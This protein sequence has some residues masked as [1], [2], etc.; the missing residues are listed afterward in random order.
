VNNPLDAVP[1]WVLLVCTVVLILAS[2]EVGVRFGKYRRHRSESEKE[3]PVGSMAA[4]ALGLL[5]F[6]LAFTFGMA[7][8][9]FDIRRD[10]VLEE[11]NALGTAYL[12][13]GFLPE[14]QRAKTQTLLREYVDIRVS[15]SQ[16]GKLE[17]VVARSEE[18]H[19]ALWAEAAS[20]G[21]KGAQPVLVGLYVQA[22]ND[23]ID[24]HAKRLSAIRSRIPTTIWFVLYAVTILSMTALGYYS[25]LND[26]H[27]TPAIVVLVLIFSAVM[28][29]IADLD[30]PREGMLTVSQQ[31]MIDLQSQLKKDAAPVK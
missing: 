26:T 1:L 31:P 12:R 15:V 7:A 11:S 13:A 2:V 6:L 25:G 27:S 18:L 14:P 28:W 23:V 17:Q 21:E 9:R 19:G 29:L 20:A 30:R 8:T 4:A 22:L 10:L 24:V 3:A 5:G 16:T